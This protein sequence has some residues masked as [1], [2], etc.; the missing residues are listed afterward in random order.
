MIGSLSQKLSSVFSSLVSSHRVTEK[1]ISDSI[2]EVRL[3]LLD[4]DVN[5]HV[6]KDFIAKVKQKILGDEVWTHVSPGQQFIRCLHEELTAFLRDG[7]EELIIE[8]RPS[9]MLL[10]G[11]Q[12][13]GKTTTVAK[14]AAHIIQKQK[15]KKVL[16]VPCDLKR[17][18]AIDQLKILVSQTQA[19]CYHTEEENSVK[20]AAQAMRYAKE[21]EHDLVIIDTAGRLHVDDTLM[22]ELAAIQQVVQAK[23]RLFV[24]NLA[25]GQDAVA[26]AQVFDKYL[27][28]TGIVFSMV[29]GD[30]RAGAVLSIKSVLGKPIKFEGCGERIQ[31]F[32]A[33]NPESMSDRI[34]GMG[35]TINFVD[36]MRQCI[37]EKENEEL[38]KKLVEATFTYED[39]YK[40]MQAF[41]RMGPLRKLLGMMPGFHN[42]KPSEKELVDSE[43]HMKKTEA[44]I[45]SMTLAER[46]EE[47]IL[48]MSRMKRIAF[49]CGLTLG[50]VN[51]FRKRMTQSKKFF[52]GMTKKRMEQMSKKMSGGNSWR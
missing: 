37:S 9:A 44:I 40:Q 5:Y 46:R 8:G 47:V 50:E 10:F 2:R 41:R 7:R 23:E 25:T 38:N 3:A 43:E 51:Q 45:L 15:A 13:S 11:L 27:D 4:A 30:A 24:M 6:V 35:D 52:K 18:A 21:K 1:N 48:D 42:T 14:L 26:T 49:G 16:V 39:Y 12:G 29:D 34:L 17:F 19:E 28:L 36:E 32:R 20:V 22:E 33:F 31:D